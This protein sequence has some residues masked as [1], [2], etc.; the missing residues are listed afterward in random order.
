MGLKKI[1]VGGG[2]IYNS[3]K[4]KKNK[5]VGFLVSGGLHSHE[6][7]TGTLSSE[8]VTVPTPPP[9]RAFPLFLSFLLTTAAAAA[10]IKKI[11]II[12]CKR[13]DDPQNTARTAK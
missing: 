12:V 8:P 4:R 10:Q 2:T 13:H 7:H 9:R 11:K 5:N 3:A 1:V 6:G